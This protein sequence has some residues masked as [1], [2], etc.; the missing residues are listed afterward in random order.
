M[1]GV[2]VCAYTVRLGWV[3]FPPGHGPVP[4]KRSM[5]SRKVYVCLLRIRMCVYD[6]QC[7]AWPG[8]DRDSEQRGR[9]ENGKKAA[10]A[11]LMWRGELIR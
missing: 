4:L 9:G 1:Y 3:Y 10:S 7:S 11:A 2:Y 8:L 6:E 5:G